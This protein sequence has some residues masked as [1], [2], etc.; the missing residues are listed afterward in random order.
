MW[1]SY[2]FY[3]SANRQKDKIHPYAKGWDA[4]LNTMSSLNITRALYPVLASKLVVSP[5]DQ[6]VKHSDCAPSAYRHLVTNTVMGTTWEK[7][8]L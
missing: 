5:I 4:T 7:H 2:S 6:T 1:P 8:F 3:P